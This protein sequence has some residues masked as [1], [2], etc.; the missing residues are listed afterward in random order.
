MLPVNPL[1]STLKEA[2]LTEPPKVSWLG[3]I[4]SWIKGVFST[5]YEFFRS[6]LKH[7]EAGDSISTPG[8]S[9][10]SSGL[11]SPGKTGERLEE[12]QNTMTLHEEIRTRLETEGFSEQE[13]EDVSQSGSVIST[14]PVT[15]FME[16][17]DPDEVQRLVDGKTL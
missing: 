11:P 10:S 14:I 5:V 9:P 4:V 8:S 17:L 3:R 2:T 16:T 6:C 15:P 7:D 12:I 13:E 1:S